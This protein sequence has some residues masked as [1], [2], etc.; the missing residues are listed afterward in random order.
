MQ[1]ERTSDHDILITLVETV[2]NNQFIVLE[3]IDDIKQKVQEVNDGISF[4]VKDHDLRIKTIERLV[5]ITSPEESK[6]ELEG[7]LEWKKQ[8]QMTWR[9]TVGSSAVVGGIIGFVLSLISGITKLTTH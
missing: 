4:T 6:K 5:Q 7:L 1:N 3:K 9:L 8:F 2:K